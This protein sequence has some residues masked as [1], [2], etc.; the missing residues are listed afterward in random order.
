MEYTEIQALQ[1]SAN[2]A[3]QAKLAELT[4]LHTLALATAMLVD[5]ITDVVSGKAVAGGHAVPAVVARRDKLEPLA[6]SLGFS[7]QPSPIY[8]GQ[9]VLVPW[10]KA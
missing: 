5:D 4:E 9:F 3:R 8:V 6:N 10:S 2:A 7:L 1:N